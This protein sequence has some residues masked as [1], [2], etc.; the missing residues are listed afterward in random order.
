MFSFKMSWLMKYFKLQLGLPKSL[1][2]SPRDH[3]CSSDWLQPEYL[4]P[5]FSISISAPLIG[6]NQDICFLLFLFPSTRKG[7]I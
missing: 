7:F 6:Y 5:S 1:S 2:L 4:L 3:F